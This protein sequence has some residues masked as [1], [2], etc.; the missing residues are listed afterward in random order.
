VQPKTTCGLKRA[1]L[2]VVVGMVLGAAGLARAG[3]FVDVPVGRTI[4]DGDAGGLVSRV[5]VSGGAG[6]LTHLRVSL[7]ISGTWNGDLYSYLAHESGFAVLLNRVGQTDA[8]GVGYGD[9]G[10]DV[11][12]D[13]DAVNGDIHSYRATLGNPEAGLAGPLSGFWSPDARAVSPFGVTE[14]MARTAFLSG[15]EGGNP[16][17]IWT[18]YVADVSGGDV[19]RLESWGLELEIQPI[20][21]PAGWA[22]NALCA[23]LLGCWL[24]LRRRRGHPSGF[25]PLRSQPIRGPRA[26]SADAEPENRLLSRAPLPIQSLWFSHS[27]ARAGF[28]TL[29]G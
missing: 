2:A 28:Q 26:L 13:D 12:F 20:P 16:N 25:Q 24:L 1:S 18:L 21:E 19:H 29:G 14:A 17:G 7:D 4:L 27:V 22:A 5:T 23:G 6:I 9:P 15:F 10:I 11:T 3:V 8:G